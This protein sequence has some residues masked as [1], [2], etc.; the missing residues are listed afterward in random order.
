MDT[1]LGPVEFVFWALFFT[2]AFGFF[3][4]YVPHIAVCI[5]TFSE[6]ENYRNM[7]T[8]SLVFNAI[9]ATALAVVIQIIDAGKTLLVL[10]YIEVCATTLLIISSLIRIRVFFE[11]PWYWIIALI[12]V[13]IVDLY[14]VLYDFG[15]NTICQ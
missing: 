12:V 13:N 6:S 2:F 9:T 14:F 8:A 5:M 7:A 15:L 3:L 11:K 4:G 10:E 1:T